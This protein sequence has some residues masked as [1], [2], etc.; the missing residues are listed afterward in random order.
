LKPET[1]SLLRKV[2]II[3][4]PHRIIGLKD[5]HKVDNEAKT[6]VNPYDSMCL[7]RQVGT[8]CGSKLLFEMDS[9]LNLKP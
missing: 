4:L 5:F 1:L 8:G 7:S 3:I 2:F 6:Y 9:T